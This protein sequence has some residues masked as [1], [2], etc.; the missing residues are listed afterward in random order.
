M[1][2]SA[3]DVFDQMG[4]NPSNKNKHMEMSRTSHTRSR[5]ACWADAICMVP[6]LGIVSALPSMRPDQTR[7]AREALEVIGRKFRIRQALVNHAH[8]APLPPRARWKQEKVAEMEE[9]N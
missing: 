9:Q 3:T 7:D 6:A 8:V 5:P 2:D 1:L 4:L